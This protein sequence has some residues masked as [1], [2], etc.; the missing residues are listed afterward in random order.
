MKTIIK[1]IITLVIILNLRSSAQQFDLMNMTPS[2]KVAVSAH[3]TVT[4]N[5]IEQFAVNN[6]SKP[7]TVTT[8][9]T[10]VVT[11]QSN[12]TSVGGENIM[13]Q[14]FSLSQNYPNPF[15]NQ[16]VIR[17]SVYQESEVTIQVYDMIGREV[18][19]LVNEAKQAGMFTVGFSNEQIASGTYIYRMTARNSNGNTFTETKKMIVMK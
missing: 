14:Q 3:Y 19:T 13:Q 2:N 15:N 17:Y 8:S 6:T 18:K 5:G 4:E 1:Y 16:T 9:D 11:K 7:F 12:T 10:L